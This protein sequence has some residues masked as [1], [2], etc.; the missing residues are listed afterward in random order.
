VYITSQNKKYVGYEFSVGKWNE[1][2]RK[3]GRLV[4]GE[5]KVRI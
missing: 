3:R 5:A 1:E 4:V 2:Y